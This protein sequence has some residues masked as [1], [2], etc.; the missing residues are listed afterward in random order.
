M[1][2]RLLPNLYLLYN[3]QTGGESGK[4]HSTVRERWLA[5]EPTFLQQVH[6][7]IENTDQAISAL[8][9]GDR[10]LLAKCLEKNFALRR[11]IYG[12]DV[13]GKANIAIAELATSLGLAVKFTGSGGAFI[14]MRKEGQDWWAEEEEREIQQEFAKH[15]FAFVRVLLPPAGEADPL[16]G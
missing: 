15:G 13:V 14:G 16:W 5:R 11:A 3:I 10:G 1:D 4:V 2:P 12:D 6:E 7:M 9:H 8:K